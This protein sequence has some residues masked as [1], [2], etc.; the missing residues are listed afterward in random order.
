M[1]G[2]GKH[3]TLVRPF[4]MSWCSSLSARV[5]WIPLT[6]MFYLVSFLSLSGS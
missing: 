5:F 4:S 1:K 6:P 3:N 2:A